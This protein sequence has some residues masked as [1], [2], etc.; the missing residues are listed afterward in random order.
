M[1]VVNAAPGGAA[2]RPSAE[3]PSPSTDRSPAGR[4]RV[5]GLRR[6][7]T[8]RA[9]LFVAVGGLAAWFAAA[10]AIQLV[11][12]GRMERALAGLDVQHARMRL[13]LQLEGSLRRQYALQ[14]LVAAGDASR[15]AEYRAER[16]AVDRLVAELASVVDEPEGRS[17]VAEIEAAT[18]ELERLFEEEVLPAA[19]ARSPDTERLHEATYRLVYAVEQGVD[20][21]VAHLQERTAAQAEIVNGV[22]RTTLRL[23]VLFLA[24]VP[25]LA[26]ALCFYLACAVAR[27][28]RAVEESA[29][30]IA[31]GDLTAHVEAGGPRDLQALG[32]Q[33]NDMAAA[34]R[35]GREELVRAQTLAGIGSA[36]AGLAHEINNPLQIVL[37]Y[38]TL[39][40]GR[41]QG[42]LGRDLE[43]IEQEARRCRD[44]LEDVLRLSRPAPPAPIAAVDLREIGEDVANA[45]H[46]ALDGRVPHFTVVGEAT[47]LAVAP[48]VR[49]ILL[50]L[51]KNAAEA[52]GPAGSVEIRVGQDGACALV[53]V[54][55][56]G[57]GVPVEVRA[58]VFEPF[59]TTK[60]NGTGLGLSIARAMARALGGELALE[61]GGGGA[62]FTLRLPL[63]GPG[64]R[65]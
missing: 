26:L 51:A 42:E 1:S 53:T 37:G 8:T 15:A 62:R 21:L 24:G 48:A 9:R 14:G 27:P 58:R 23:A 13:A 7:L 33:V 38:V 54:T 43:R 47:A 12:L 50:N 30:R 28:L 61:D 16:P 49:Q 39:H 20:A 3:N 31:A 29:G 59:F 57:P 56:D 2:E 46:V 6:R 52:A 11:H 10:F 18:G 34:L 35:R 36:A 40:R 64:E 22:R 45:L 63:A 55:D 60:R 5:R 65:S 32:A 41:V 25:L 17:R 44:I 19:L 4:A